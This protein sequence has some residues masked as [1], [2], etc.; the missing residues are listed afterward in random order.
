MPSETLTRAI[1]KARELPDVDQERIGRELSAYVDDLRKLR[2]D[3][4]EGLRS[5]VEPGLMA[6]H[7]DFNVAR[8]ELAPA[9]WP[10]KS[11]TSAS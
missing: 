10:N 8:A 9:N 5:L 6:C 3:L 7:Q 11:A 4:A 2:A 1:A